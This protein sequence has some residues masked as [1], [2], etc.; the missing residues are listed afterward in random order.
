MRS[1]PSGSVRVF[2]LDRE[3]VLK[4]LEAVARQM[5]AARPEIEEVWLFGSLARGDAAPGSD[6][7][8]LLVLS[9]ASGTFAERIPRY[10]P[11]GLSLGVEV[12]PYTRVEIDA[13]LEDENPFIRQALAEGIALG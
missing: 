1:T 2:W 9:E 10:L 12:F 7:D 6:A 4:E 13:M 3:A 8:L 5:K 11:T